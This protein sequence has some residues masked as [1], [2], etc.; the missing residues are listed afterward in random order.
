MQ[1]R[2]GNIPSPRDPNNSSWTSPLKVMAVVFWDRKVV[3]LVDFM[4]K[5]TSVNAVT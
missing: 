2:T 3:W 1:I 4:E 5:A